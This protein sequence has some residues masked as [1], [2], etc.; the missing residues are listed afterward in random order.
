MCIRDSIYAEQARLQDEA[1]LDPLLHINLTA[2][3]Q[4]YYPENTLACHLVGMLALENEN[5]SW[6]TGY[7]GLEGYYDNFLRQRNGV[8][9]TARTEAGLADLPGEVRRFLPSV[10]AKDLV[11]TIDRTV[12]WIAQDELQKGLQKYRAKA[13]TIIVM[14]P[15]SGA[16]LALSLIHI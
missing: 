12:Q 14:D 4:R 13:G 10:A 8:G 1:G 6:L 11:L 2:T 16:V 7:Y 15:H 9:L 5:S 3:P